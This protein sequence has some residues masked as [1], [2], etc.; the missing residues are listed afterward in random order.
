M[1]SLT[2]YLVIVG[3]LIA[4]GAMLLIVGSQTITGDLVIEEGRINNLTQLE[5]SAELDPEI[6]TQGVYAIQTIEGKEY[7]A[8]L[9]L[10][11]PKGIDVAGAIQFKI[12]GEVY[13]DNEF[14]VRAGY[15]ANASI[16]TS[17]KENVLSIDEALI[18]FD[19]RTKKAFVE[20]EVS[21]QKFERRDIETGISDG[22]YAELISGVTKED[23][24]KIWNK[25][26]PIKR[27][28]E[29]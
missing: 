11:S 8:T 2:K 1:S 17:V 9:N 16:I 27:G 22:V 5:I 20:V 29:E 6:N 19:N 12:E 26:E 15:S 23:K 14:V 21:D 7:D 28:E 18:Q 4:I 10:I 3:V 24:I 13:I 25:T